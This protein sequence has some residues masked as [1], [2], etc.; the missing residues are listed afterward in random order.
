MIATTNIYPP[1]PDRRFD[2][3]AYDDDVEEGTQ[4]FGE[5]EL[6][7]IMDYAEQVQADG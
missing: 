1:I 2:W 5:T 4:G 6:E 7:A 3:C